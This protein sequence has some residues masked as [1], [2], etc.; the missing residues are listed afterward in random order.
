LGQFHENIC[1]I[2]NFFKQKQ[3]SCFTIE[4]VCCPLE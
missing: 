3:F 2:I 4:L 1:Y